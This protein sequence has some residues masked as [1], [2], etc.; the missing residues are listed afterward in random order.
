MEL[1]KEALKRMIKEELEGVLGEEE[2]ERG[3]GFK[4]LGK[5][6]VGLPPVD[7]E[8]ARIDAL[9]AKADKDRDDSEARWKKSWARDDKKQKLKVKMYKAQL[10]HYS[11]LSPDMKLGFQAHQKAK[12]GE[13]LTPE[14]T[15]QRTKYLDALNAKADKDRDDRETRS[16]GTD[17]EKRKIRAMIHKAL[18][19]RF[20]SLSPD[21]KL[22]FQAH[23]KA[24]KGKELTPE[25]TT[26]MTKYLAA[27]RAK[28][29][30]DRKAAWVHA[31]KTLKQFY[32]DNPE[33][34]KL[35][36]N[37]GLSG[38]PLAEMIKEDLEGVLGEQVATIAT[39]RKIKQKL[40]IGHARIGKMK[41][42]NEALKQIIKEELEAVLEMY[43]TDTGSKGVR[44]KNPTAQSDRMTPDVAMGMLDFDWNDLDKGQKDKIEGVVRGLKNNIKNFKGPEAIQKA[45]DQ[46]AALTAA[47]AKSKGE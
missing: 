25:E 27:S 43:M 33:A 47:I 35:M 5:A 3:P 15:T 42:T 30:K 34:A 6:V 28:E 10:K 8:Q 32:K 7:K 1:T 24:Q 22:G 18:L 2:D 20:S 40:A 16:W 41:L 39:K 46:L 14:E 19:Q 11:S 17:P 9:N 21:M 12:K 37:R 44:Y 36:K 29:I 31:N 26:Q 4:G 23:Q 13:E 38:E 45:K